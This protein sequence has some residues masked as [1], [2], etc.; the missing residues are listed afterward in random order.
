MT[1]RRLAQWV[2]WAAALAGVLTAG[3]RPS[4]AEESRPGHVYII[5]WFDTEDY[6]LPQSDD[7]AKRIAVFLTGQGV[8]ATFKVVGEKGRTLE[9]RGRQD[10][11]GALARHEIGYHSNAHSQ[12]PTVAEYESV[13][14]WES[15]IE[16]FTRRERPGFDDLRRIFGQ[17]PTC[18]GQPGSS[19]APQPYGALKKW[20]VKVYL[21]E[22]PHV[23]LNGKPF[24]YGGLLNIFNT[25]EGPQL[26]PNDDWSNLADAKAKFQQ[27]YTRISSRPEGGIISLYF[28]PCEFV[29]REFWDATNFARGANPPADQWKLPPTKS[30]EESERAFQYLEGLVAY[31]KPFP[32]VKFV[33]ASEALQL[34]S[35]A[36]QN[37]VF[38][39]QELGEI[40][41]QVDPQV[42]FQVRSGY[43]LSPSEVFTLLNKFV[44]GVVRKK[45]SEPILLEGSPYGP[46]SGG[47]ELKEEIQVP[48]SQFSRTTLDVSSALESTGQIPNVVWLGSA[49][50][51]PESYLVALAHVAGTLLMKGEPP[52]SVTVPPASLA[53]AQYVAQ[54]KP[55]LWDWIIFPQ[56]FDPPHLMDLAR[57]QAWTLKPAIIRGSP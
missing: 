16:E 45:A 55:Q 31:M 56:G 9:R 5:L 4:R 13:M 30:N 17:S 42:T 23:G 7:A 26:R 32:G 43:A 15:G 18:Y 37:R 3:A 33:T 21:D 14:G 24:W 50:V 47:G 2:L 35:D 39:T 49:A 10:V 57:L 54:D 51:P 12:H 11:I 38:S 41:K 6:I 44:S 8:R 46:E 40:S 48:W 22:A 53:A 52:E 20:G 1:M 34:Y 27:F 19:W 36:A 25:T 28:H 29:H